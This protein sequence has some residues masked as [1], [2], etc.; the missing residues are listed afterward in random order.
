MFIVNNQKIDN[1]SDETLLEAWKQIPYYQFFSGMEHFTWELPCDPNSITK[2]RNRI[3]ING[4]E[5]IFKESIS[6][7]GAD[8]LESEE[9]LLNR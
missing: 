8:A 3:G 7:N 1:L 4:I 9:R 2:F 6:V 5:E